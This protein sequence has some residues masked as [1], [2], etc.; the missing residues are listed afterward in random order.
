MARSVWIESLG[1]PKNE[2]DGER[3]RSA[4]LRK[5]FRV[6][7]DRNRADLL[8]LNTCG[9]IQSA[10]EESIEEIFDLIELKGQ[11]GQKKVLVCGCLAQRYPDELWNQ[12][13]ELDGVF[14]LGQIDKVDSICSAALRG[15]RILSVSPLG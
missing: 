1:C 7:S 13:P 8:I 12:M 3:M 11:N 10:K 4:L 15:E 2:V 5:G 14:G 6:V 9:F